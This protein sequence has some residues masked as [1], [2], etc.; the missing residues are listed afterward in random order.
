MREEESGKVG[1]RTKGWISFVNKPTFPYFI[2][3]TT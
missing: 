3:K 2:V 1:A